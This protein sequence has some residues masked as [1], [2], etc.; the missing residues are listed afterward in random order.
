MFVLSLEE[1]WTDY[2]LNIHCKYSLLFRGSES[3]SGTELGQ[4]VITGE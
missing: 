2:S 3:I 1:A 4:K